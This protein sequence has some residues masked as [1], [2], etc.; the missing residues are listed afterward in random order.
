MCRALDQLRAQP[1]RLFQT[2]AGFDTIGARLVGAGDDAG[3]LPTVSN[4]HGT[5]APFGTV[6]LFDGGEEGVH[7][8]QHN[9]PRPD[10]RAVVAEIRAFHAGG[11]AAKRHENGFRGEGLSIARIRIG[12]YQ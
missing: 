11:V 7:V 6:A 5:A 9:G 4:R 2:H 8:H 10:H 12:V 3:A 1:A